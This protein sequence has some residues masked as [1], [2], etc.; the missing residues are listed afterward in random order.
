MTPKINKSVKKCA[1][2]LYKPYE[3][4][5]NNTD[6]F[7]QLNTLLNRTTKLQRKHFDFIFQAQ[8][9]FGINVSLQDALWSVWFYTLDK[10][11]I[12]NVRLD[13]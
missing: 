6:K 5:I 12:N 11:L 2:T 7:C 13:I 3:N 8:T 1:L 4:E 10:M 9:K